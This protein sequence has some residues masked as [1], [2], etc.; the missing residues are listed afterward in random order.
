[1]AGSTAK[2]LQNFSCGDTLSEGANQKTE[3]VRQSAGVLELPG[4][5]ISLRSSATKCGVAP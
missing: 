1:M 5:R 3:H 2:V 4:P